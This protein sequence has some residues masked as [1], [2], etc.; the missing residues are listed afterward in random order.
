MRGW[1]CLLQDMLQ[2]IKLDLRY[3]L[4]ADRQLYSSLFPFDPVFGFGVRINDCEYLVAA[5]LPTTV[6]KAVSCQLT[7]RC[8]CVQKRSRRVLFSTLP[9]VLL[10]KSASENSIRLGSL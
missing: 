9:V 3:S 2:G 1:I 7:A 4:M 10:G 8:W 6:M 5:C